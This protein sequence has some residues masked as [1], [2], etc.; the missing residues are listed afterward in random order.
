MKINKLIIGTLTL[1]LS[2]SACQNK[3]PDSETRDSLIYISSDSSL[4][5]MDTTSMMANIDTN[6]MV[7][8]M[9][10]VMER[11]MESMHQVE[12]TGNMDYDL[13]SM[14]KL[15]HQGAIDMSKLE[16]KLGTEPKQKQI[17]RNIINKQAKEIQMLDVLLGQADKTKNYEPS[18]KETGLGKDMHENMMQMMN[19]EAVSPGTPDHEF[20]SVM[21]KHHKDGIDMGRIIVKY[22]RTERFKAMAKKMIDDQTKEITE[23]EKTIDHH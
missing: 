4:M 15:H 1:A 8:E 5:K 3:T 16:I 12:M 13:I 6:S 23:L 20:T 21:I 17:A 10:K 14:L 18:N 2:F 19:M 7:T 9:G 22:S 11:M